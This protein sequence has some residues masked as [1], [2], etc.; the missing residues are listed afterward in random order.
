MTDVSEPSGTPT[1][2]AC[3][4]RSCG[5]ALTRHQRAW[6]CARGHGF[7]IAKSGYVNLLQPQ[8][9]KSRQAGDT[10]AAVA[11]RE[12]LLTAGIGRT[13]LDRFV[14][15]AAALDLPDRPNVVDLGCG[16]GDLL[17]G[18]RDR[19]GTA[20]VGIDLSTAAIERAARRFPELTWVIANADRRLPVLD[21]SL[22]LMLSFNGRRNATECARVLRRGGFV[23]AAVPAEDDLIELRT[24]V[25][26]AGVV[27]DR[28]E[29]LLAEFE[30]F[31]IVERLAVREQHT[32]DGAA[33]SDLLTG[34]YRGARASHAAARDELNRLTVTLA[35]DFVLFGRHT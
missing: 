21:R 8:D 16:A 27:R 18:L 6:T 11:A 25:Q 7:D 31:D 1:F 13:V 30:G 20:S 23:L 12:R 9:R 33:L 15:R 19:R 17:A 24:Q 5:L 22:D 10:A 2:L 35:S 4:V 26:G 32:L 34:T 14:E 28:V 29:V 3:S